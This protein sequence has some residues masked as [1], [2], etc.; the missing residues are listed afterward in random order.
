MYAPLQKKENKS[1]GVANSMPKNKSVAKQGVRFIDNRPKIQI[2][3]DLK[4]LAS[5][6]ENLHSFRLSGKKN[7]LGNNVNTTFNIN[8]GTK[9]I[10]PDSI[11]FKFHPEGLVQCK[12]KMLASYLK[13]LKYFEDRNYMVFKGESEI[14]H[15]GWK[16]H[17]GAAKNEGLD[18]AKAVSFLRDQKIGHK[19]DI[20]DNDAGAVN[21]FLTV[22]P[23]ADEA[24][25]EMVIHQ[26]ETIMKKFDGTEIDGDMRVKSSRARQD[27][28]VDDYGQVYMR[29]GQNTMLKEDNVGGIIEKSGKQWGYDV[30]KSS[31]EE[32]IKFDKPLLGTDGI[33]F[34]PKTDTQPQSLNPNTVYMAILYG[35]KIVPDR[36][37]TPNPAEA[38]LPPGVNEYGKNLR[39]GEYWE[40]FNFNPT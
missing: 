38:E 33:L 7:K 22:Y 31:E 24:D 11:T 9:L 20:S 27:E 19:F 5:Q 3:S 29:H 26:L 14:D 1:R 8:S 4:Q 32:V 34:F 13:G 40:G 6:R 28:N 12:N 25:W 2:E 23:P 16:A 35:G 37:E 10:R 17:I 39:P 18:I 30:Y 15:V 21:K 36:R